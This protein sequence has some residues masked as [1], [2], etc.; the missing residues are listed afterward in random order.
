MAGHEY[1]ID[2]LARLAG[3][4][5]RNVRA[6]QDRGLLPSPR[7]EGRVGLYSEAHLGRL[8][9][10]GTLL[11]RGYT[12]ANIAELADAWERGRDIGDLFGFEAILSAPWSEEASTTA[13]AEQL[14]ELV[15]GADP[16]VADF[17]LREATRLGI[18]EAEG[19]H[20]RVLAPAVFE[21]GTLLL[22]AGVPLE[23][24]LVLARAMRQHIEEVAALFVDVVDTHICAPWGDVIPRNE[25][26]ALAELIEQLRPL[27][28]RVV[29]SE[30]S[31]AMDRQI[32]TRFGEVIE[33]MLDARPAG[34]AS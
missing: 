30:L 9:L 22:R 28:K 34:E 26:P 15:A 31:T 16:A 6:Y 21:T 4:T 5:V 8:R 20:F 7:R 10:I 27:A 17:A 19:D 14:A 18:V 2:E 3:T 25:L 1:R 11:E 23:Q 29:E 13:S 32:Q 24:V 33:R 12:L